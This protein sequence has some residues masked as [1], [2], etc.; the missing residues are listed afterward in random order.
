MNDGR[1][2]MESAK[3]IGANGFVTKSEPAVV[4]LKAVGALSRKQTFFPALFGAEQLRTISRPDS[5]EDARR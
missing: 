5:K 2:L 1:A 3:A 4:I